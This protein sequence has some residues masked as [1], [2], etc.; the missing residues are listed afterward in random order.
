MQVVHC[1]SL[2]QKGPKRAGHVTP[3]RCALSAHWHGYL[4]V[5]TKPYMLCVF[6]PNRLASNKAD[7]VQAASVRW[8]EPAGCMSRNQTCPTHYGLAKMRRPRRYNSVSL[9]MR[10]QRRGAENLAVIRHSFGARPD[11]GIM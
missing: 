10:E 2:M 4:R 3:S 8:M 6:S 5:K 9:M 11:A 7:E 1:S